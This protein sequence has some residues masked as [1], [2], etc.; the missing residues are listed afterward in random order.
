MQWTSVNFNLATSIFLLWVCLFMPYFAWTTYRKVKSGAPLP[1]MGRR[2]QS[3]ILLLLLVGYTADNV[4]LS[5]GI[6]LQ[7]H[8]TLWS[9]IYGLAIVIGLVVSVVRKRHQWPLEHRERI[10]K[11]YAPTNFAEYAWS[12]GAA[13]CAG[14]CEEIAYRG[15]LYA[16]AARLTRDVGA[17]VV[18]CIVFFVLA[19]LPQGLRGAIGVA[20]LASIFHVIYLLSGSLLAPILMHALYDVCLFTILF[21]DERHR[22]ADVVQEEQ[23]VA[24]TA[25]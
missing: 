1:S 24:Q 19:H 23:A 12:I 15:V 18:L 20:M 5:N 17:A 3:G 8:P 2:F 4:S 6:E 13:I 16:L 11:L 9:L 21:N 25:S 22:P 14:V 10:R 7:F